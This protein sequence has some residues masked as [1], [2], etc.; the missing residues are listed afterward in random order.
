[1]DSWVGSMTENVHGDDEG[2]WRRRVVRR[3][4]TKSSPSI[5][6]IPTFAYELDSLSQNDDIS[7]YSFVVEVLNPPPHIG[8]RKEK[9]FTSGV[10][11]P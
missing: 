5:F 1:M 4:T 3:V 8:D 9:A 7:H 6:N 2:G 10:C 11:G